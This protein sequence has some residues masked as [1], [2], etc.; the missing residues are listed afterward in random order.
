MAGY[1]RDPEATSRA[2]LGGGWLRTGDAARADED[3]DVWIVDRIEDAYA[4]SE[5]RMFPADVER[6]LL[7]H[8]AVADVGVVGVE[9]RAGRSEGVAF[10]VLADTAEASA[11]ELLAFARAALGT[12]SEPAS[13]VFVESLP[14]NV[15]GK[16]MRGALRDQAPGVELEQGGG[17]TCG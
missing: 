5:G 7:E 1:W 6:A 15:V 12:T 13:V 10:V 16:L 3:G 17:T 8:P 2:I 9:R 11:D 14:R 4:S